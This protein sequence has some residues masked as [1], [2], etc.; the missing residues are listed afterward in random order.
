MGMAGVPRWMPLLFFKMRTA[1]FRFIILFLNPKDLL[2]S[3]TCPLKDEDM[4]KPEGSRQ[5]NGHVTR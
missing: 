2:K 5:G 4:G 3:K 1:G